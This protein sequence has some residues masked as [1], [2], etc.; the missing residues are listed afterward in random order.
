M[1]EGRKLLAVLL[2]TVA[3]F[4]ACSGDFERDVFRRVWVDESG[5]RLVVEAGNCTADAR[6]DE[7]R[8]AADSVTII[9][10]VEFKNTDDCGGVSVPIELEEPLGDRFVTNGTTGQ[11]VELYGPGA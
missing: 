8:E 7:V 10:S 6:V 3:I 4:S 5:T 11:P 1:G 2:L 9:V